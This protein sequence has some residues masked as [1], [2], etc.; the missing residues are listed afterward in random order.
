[1]MRSFPIFIAPSIGPRLQRR[2]KPPPPKQFLSIALDYGTPSCKNC[3][4]EFNGLCTL[5]RYSTLIDNQI[6]SHPM[7]DPIQF[8]LTVEQ[9]R[10]ETFLC[11][12]GGEYFKSK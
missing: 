11:G 1:M 5:F 12:P 8:Y 4:Y 9:C 10:K 3:K 2:I 6:N 7:L